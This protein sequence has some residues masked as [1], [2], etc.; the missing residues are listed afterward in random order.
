MVTMAAMVLLLLAS[1]LYCR[2]HNLSMSVFPERF[3]PVCIIVSALVFIF[4]IVT[5]IITKVD[6]TE[7]ILMLLYGSLVTPLF[8]ELLFRGVI[9]NKL[10]GYFAKEYVTYIVVTV[11]FA[12]WHIG[13]AIGIY[14][15]T[16]GNLLS[17]VCMKVLIGG[18][19]GLIT[20]AIRYKTKN[21]YLGILAHGVMNLFG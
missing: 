13:Y 5:A 21:C 19:Y 17:C 7:K 11:L 15:W 8:E 2:K 18:I 16:G 12:L 9:W 14:L 10:N 20:G 6:S 3:G 1:V 4:Y